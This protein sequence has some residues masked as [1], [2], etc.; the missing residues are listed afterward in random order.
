MKKS[1]IASALNF[2]LIAGYLAAM[3]TLRRW[4]STM[5][6][7]GPISAMEPSRCAN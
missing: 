4:V 1:Q 6:V 5:I 7:P 2:P 3:A